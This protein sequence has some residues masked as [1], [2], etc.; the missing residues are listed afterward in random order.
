MQD[1]LAVLAGCRQN[2]IAA[3][4]HDFAA[5]LEARQPWT[6]WPAEPT[7]VLSLATGEPQQ[8]LT[9]AEFNARSRDWEIRHTLRPRYELARLRA[10][11]PIA[12]RLSQADM[13]AMSA[14]CVTAMEA[15][16]AAA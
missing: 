11:R 9:R 14:R 13:L 3:K 15:L 7:T 5:D 1:P 4:T 12:S 16:R 8:L 6:K 10:M 2:L